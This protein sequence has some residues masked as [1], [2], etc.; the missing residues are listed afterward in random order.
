MKFLLSPVVEN[1]ILV[2]ALINVVAVLL[3]FFT[4]RFVP[5][6]KIARPLM[7]KK[8]FKTCYKYHS[9]IWWVLAPSVLIHAVIAIMHKLS[10]G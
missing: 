6:V 5:S 8:W 3:L 9:Y 1:I 2:T 7:N 4:C 10:G